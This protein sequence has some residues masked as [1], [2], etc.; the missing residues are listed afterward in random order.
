MY[1]FR[2]YPMIAEE[3]KKMSKER[4]LRMMDRHIA[5]GA[6]HR[7]KLSVQVFSSSYLSAMESPT[8]DEVLITDVIE[9]K[10]TAELFPLHKSLD[11][12]QMTMEAILAKSEELNN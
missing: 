8:E 5:K 11:V 7:Q 9:F 4:V 3:V 6:P 12:S 1:L 10:R 2:K